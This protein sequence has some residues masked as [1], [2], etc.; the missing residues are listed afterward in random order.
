MIV[1]GNVE[2]EEAGVD[3]HHHV[4]QEEVGDDDAS[5]T[6]IYPNMSGDRIEQSDD[7][8]DQQIENVYI[9]LTCH[10][11]KY[12]ILGCECILQ[13]VYV[14]LGFFENF[15]DFSSKYSLFSNS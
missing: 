4:E 6:N 14:S 1:D 5:N 9:Y 8:F 7:G 2:K 11:L 10:T 12:S 15:L 3:A 13:C